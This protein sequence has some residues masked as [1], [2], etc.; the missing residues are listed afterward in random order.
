MADSPVIDSILDSVKKNLGIDPAYTHFDADITLLINGVFSTLNQLGIGPVDGFM[1]EDK[2]AEWDEFT[3]SDVLLNSV[4][5]YVFL[6]V[7]VVFDPPATGYLVTAYND[8]I[9]ELEWRLNTYR[10]GLSWQDPSPV[11]PSILL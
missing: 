10:E 9:K 7:R 8:Q 2:S 1:I 4:K 6:K 5:T 11:I 3:G